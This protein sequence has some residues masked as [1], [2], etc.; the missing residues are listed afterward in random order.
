MAAEAWVSGSNGR[1]GKHSWAARFVKILGRGRG[2]DQVRL[3][4]ISDLMYPAKVMTQNGNL[5]VGVKAKALV[6]PPCR[7]IL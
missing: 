4:T 2:G 1:D 5:L 6:E 3:A 7:F